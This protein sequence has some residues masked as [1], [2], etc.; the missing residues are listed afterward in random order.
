MLSH[1]KPY[2]PTTERDFIWIAEYANGTHLAEYDF[3]SKKHNDFSLIRKQDVIRFGLFGHGYR[4]FYETVGGRFF[5]PFGYV[6]FNLKTKEKI[7]NLTSNQFMYTDMITYKQAEM[8]FNPLDGYGTG[9]SIITEYVFGYKQKLKFDDVNFSIKI[10]VRIAEDTPVYFD[11]KMVSN[12]DI[13]GTIQILRHDI[14]LDE[15]PVT[16]T[17]DIN[18]TF[19]WMVS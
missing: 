7:Y 4:F 3:I 14:I 8:D 16:L 5:T 12:Q 9:K 10:L 15:Y 17:K 19:Q 2:S 1:I 18:S 11:V 13:D 6:D